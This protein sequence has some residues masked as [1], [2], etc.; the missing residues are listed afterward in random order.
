MEKTPPKLVIRNHQFSRQICYFCDTL[1]IFLGGVIPH[2][3]FWEQKGKNTH[4]NVGIDEISVRSARFRD[5][6]LK[7]NCKNL[8]KSYFFPP[9]P[10]SG[11]DIFKHNFA[12]DCCLISPAKQ[13]Q[14]EGAGW[15][16]APEMK[17]CHHFLFFFVGGHFVS[18]FRVQGGRASASPCVQD[19]DLM[20]FFLIQNR[21]II[22]Q[23]AR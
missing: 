4:L 10:Q 1:Q 12:G 17:N 11:G 13:F 21:P 14:G 5:N 19:L 9:F 18:H 2:V 20:A 16:S 8:N 15:P 22:G 7:K 3:R 6:Y 23:I